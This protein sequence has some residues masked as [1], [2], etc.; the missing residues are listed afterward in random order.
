MKIGE[1]AEK[2]NLSTDTVRYYI[3]N[4]MI[5][6]EKVHNRYHFDETCE[7]S[8]DF[9]LQFKKMK[10]TIEEIKHILTY[11]RMI[12]KTGKAE[13]EY[14]LSI[15]N[16]KIDQVAKEKEEFNIA[17]EKLEKIKKDYEKEIRDAKNEYKTYSI[18][19]NVLHFLACPKCQKPLKLNNA[20]I[21]N[22]KIENGDLYCECGY[23]AKIENGMIVTEDSDKKSFHKSYGEELS[24][25]SVID[26][27]DSEYLSFLMAP[28]YWMEKRIN[29]KDLNGKNILLARPIGHE[30]PYKFIEN[31]ENANIFIVDYQYLRMKGLKKR[32]EKTDLSSSSN[33][34]FMAFDYL[35]IP[36]KHNS[37][38]YILDLSGMINY[39]SN[40]NKSPLKNFYDILKYNGYIFSTFF[41]KESRDNIFVKEFNYLDKL[42]TRDFI[43]LEYSIFEKEDSAVIQGSNFKTEIDRFMKKKSRLD[44]FVFKGKKVEG[45]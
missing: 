23:E 7:K 38:D 39:V 13:T 19:I 8:M 42:Y 27:N 15:I 22:N 5:I 4:G 34:V 11:M 17:L 37:F 14:L 6:P 33:V 28:S 10:F 16:N 9:I 44:F 12:P 32:M 30:I 26:E 25:K 41:L 1:F 18:P 24:Y 29:L 36:L 20:S 43:D 2:Y 40:T 31:I 21:K 3:D 35:T 45:E